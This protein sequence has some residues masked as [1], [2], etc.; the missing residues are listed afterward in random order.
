MTKEQNVLEEKSASGGDCCK[1]VLIVTSALSFAA[2]FGFVNYVQFYEIRS[3]QQRV[4][5]LEVAQTGIT[6]DISIIAKLSDSPDFINILRKW[7]QRTPNSG[8]R[9]KRQVA[10]GSLSQFVTDLVNQEVRVFETYCG[11]SSKICLPGPPGPKGD[12]GVKGDQGDIG[13]PGIPGPKGEQ[14]NYGVPGIPGEKGEPGQ[15]GPAGP[16]GDKGDDARPLSIEQQCCSALAKPSYQ[17]APTQVV[18]AYSGQSVVLPCKTFGYPPPTVQFTPIT[19]PLGL[20]RYLL[21]QDGLQIQNVK[22][23]D[24]GT[25]TC[26]VTNVFGTVDKHIQLSVTERVVAT[27]TPATINVIAGTTPSF[28][29]TC[30]VS[31]TPSPAVTW[32]HMMLDGSNVTVTSG[33]SSINGQSTLTVTNPQQ[34]DAGVYICSAKN[35]YETDEARTVVTTSGTPQIIRGPKTQSVHEGDT[36]IIRC[37]IVSNPPATVKWTFPL[38][39][40]KPPLNAQLN[41]DNSVTL[42]DVDHFNNGDYV[43]TATNAVGS[44]SA[45]A[46]LAVHKV[47][48]AKVNQALIPVT[49][50]EPVITLQCTGNGDPQPS[51]T[52]TKDEQPLTGSKY[53]FLTGGNLVVTNV[54]VNTDIG[55]YK[56]IANNGIENATDLSIE[57]YEEILNAH[58]QRNEVLDLNRNIS[59]SLDANE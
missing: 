55:K 3:L 47:V 38:T 40:D 29:I 36:V 19:D 28:T 33:I 17:G 26:K 43:C 52:W 48:T 45:T 31:G 49:G 16:K 53:L 6:S 41:P 12:P 20:G 58:S 56:C 51:I 7:E 42:I 14:G 8:S 18:S 2:V 15:Q 10:S 1:I 39:G 35:I 57:I 9:K 27:T 23:S 21:V 32:Y 11:N 4:H 44:T 25:Y 5:K 54:D 46:G 34:A 30:D 13:Y 50:T 59:L 22:L 24:S 37:D